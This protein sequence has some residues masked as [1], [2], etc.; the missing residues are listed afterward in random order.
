MPEDTSL[1]VTLA[2]PVAIVAIVNWL[3]ALGINGRWATLAA[4]VVAQHRAQDRG[5]GQVVLLA[6]GEVLQLD[7]EIAALVVAR[8][9][10]RAERR[11]AVEGGQAAPHHAGVLVHERAE[12]AI[13]DDAEV[14]GGSV[15]AG[16]LIRGGGRAGAR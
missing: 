11:V 16:S 15:H 5:G 10:Q 14:E 6:A 13:A 1:V 4:V 9:Q 3:K 7:R 2:S 8:G 12:T